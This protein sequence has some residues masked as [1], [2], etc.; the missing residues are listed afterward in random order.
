MRRV[1]VINSLPAI[2]R[3]V[4]ST[5]QCHEQSPWIDTLFLW[6]AQRLCD[7]AISLIPPEE[8]LF[9]P[10]G[11]LQR[12]RDQSH[13]FTAHARLIHKPITVRSRAVVFRDRRHS[14]SL[15]VRVFAVIETAVKVPLRD[16][17]AMVTEA[18]PTRRRN[19]LTN[20]S[21]EHPCN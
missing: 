17:L 13:V 18:L 2:G 21:Q 5:V 7:P 11:K 3:V 8:I 4:R 14:S 6:P 15:Q 20:T 1:C 19:H 16:T 9:A 12:L 10:I